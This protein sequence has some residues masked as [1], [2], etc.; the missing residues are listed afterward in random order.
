MH[1]VQQFCNEAFFVFNNLLVLYMCY[2]SD[3]SFQQELVVGIV[4]LTGF[5]IFV[6][7]NLT[8]ILWTGISKLKHIS[9]LVG[10]KIY[11]AERSVAER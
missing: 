8:I 7:A 3:P 2:R 10:N 4:K 9:L 6:L 5:V 1:F 11:P